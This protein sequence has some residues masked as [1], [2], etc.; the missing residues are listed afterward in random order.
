MLFALSVSA[1]VQ[2]ETSV[3]DGYTPESEDSLGGSG[4]SIGFCE[5]LNQYGNATR[6]LVVESSFD[7]G[8]VFGVSAFELSDGSWDSTLDSP[9]AGEVPNKM[10]NMNVTLQDDDSW[11]YSPVATWPS[12]PIAKLRFFAYYPFSDDGFASGVADGGYPTVKAPIINSNPA[13]QV[14]YM[15]ASTG[16]LDNS[17]SNSVILAFEHVLTQ[18][19]FNINY[20]TEDL[21]GDYVDCSAWTIKLYGIT[22]SDVG[23]HTGVGRFSDEGDFGFEWDFDSNPELVTY[24]LRSNS[25]HLVEDMEYADDVT[26]NYKRATTNSGLLLLQPQTLA[27]GQV[28]V[29]F[30]FSVNKN[31]GDDSEEEYFS[32]SVKAGEHQYVMGKRVVYQFT[33]NPLLAEEYD[34][35]TDG[36][37]DVDVGDWEDENKDDTTLGSDSVDGNTGEL[38]GENGWGEDNEDDTTLGSDSVDGN[39]DDVT[40]DDSWAGS[41]GNDNDFSGGS[42]GGDSGELEGENG[43]GEDNEDDTTLGSDSVDGNVDDVT[44]DDSWSGSGGHDND[45]SGGTADGN[46]GDV[47]GDGSWGG[48]GGNDNDFSSGS[49]GGDSGELEGENGWGEDN[50]D[51][52]TLGSDGVDGN[53]GDV[54]GDGSWGGSGGNDNDFSSG[55][56]GGDSGEL[57]GENGWG[58]DNK[59]DTTLG[60]DGVDGNVGDVT[61][62]GSWAGS[63]G[64]D[65]DFSDS[66]TGDSGDIDGEDG[67]EG[68]GNGDGETELD[69]GS[70]G[71]DTGGDG[72]GNVGGDGNW[73]DE[74]KDETE[75][76]GSGNNSVE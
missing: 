4:Y 7:V 54:T 9:V 3:Y 55:S 58:E 60:S 69:G 47:T 20:V 8:S 21:A 1:C 73:D 31:D 74:T 26:P 35:L 57:E 6:G 53:V 24:E 43:W 25:G 67:W 2:T 68:E 75:L 51:D 41:G 66:S 63:G 23:Q 62:D 48:S 28:G 40:G 30:I 22:L 72:G 46:V 64:N 61:G 71:G 12:N 38:E 76:G 27:A 39:V 32:Q 5:E 13:E 15:V 44:G 34:E 52:T 59:D 19:D 49:A 50:K 56:A 11:T 70:T 16:L 42:A 65:N 36:D 14:D 37:V 10:Y 17:T 29:E 45:F 18:V 33:V